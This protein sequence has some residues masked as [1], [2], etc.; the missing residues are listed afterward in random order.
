[1][2]YVVPAGMSE[3]VRMIRGDRTLQ[4]RCMFRLCFWYFGD[5]C[6]GTRGLEVYICM[7]CGCFV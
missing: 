4:D 2:K 5:L 6:E 7:G 1:M 3:C